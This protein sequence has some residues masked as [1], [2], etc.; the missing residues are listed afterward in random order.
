[1]VYM[2]IRYNAPVSLT[3]ALISSLVLGADELLGTDLVL[4]LFT[5]PPSN[6]FSF[7]NPADWV[8]LVTHVIGHSGWPHLIGNFA[9]ILLLGPIL[10]EKHGSLPILVMVAIT[11]LVTGLLNV[12]FSGYALLGASGVVFMMILLVS[13]TNFRNGEI[14]LTFLLV[15]A[16]YVVRELI[17]SFDQD[18]IAQ[19]AHIAGGVCGSMFGFLRTGRSRSTK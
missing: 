14:P 13:F 19:F 17:A 8:R 4:Q 11:A 18:G 5:V 9:F 3:F 10:E 1:M 16:L 12:F 6:A 15:I 2:K 7:S